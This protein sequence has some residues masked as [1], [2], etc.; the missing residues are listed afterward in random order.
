MRRRAVLVSGDLEAHGASTVPI[1]YSPLP[2]LPMP[3]RLLLVAYLLS[4]PTGG[5]TWPSR[6]WAPL[7]PG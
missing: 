4:H 2:T 5:G 6:A 1:W 7:S 3:R